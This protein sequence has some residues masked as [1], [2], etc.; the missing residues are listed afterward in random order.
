M[1]QSY[2]KRLEL[3]DKR[4]TG[5]QIAWLLVREFE[6]DSNESGVL[7]EQEIYELVLVKDNVPS[8]LTRW[9]Q[10]I[11]ECRKL[12]AETKEVL[13]TKQ[14]QKS[15]QLKKIFQI[16]SMALPR[17]STREVMTLFGTP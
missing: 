10:L 8:F 2:D 9:D 5:R 1:L 4:L 14:I 7:K 15:E 11:F 3:E 16:I 17:T 13:F 6:I 12:D